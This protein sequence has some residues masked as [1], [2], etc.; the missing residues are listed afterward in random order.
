M[1]KLYAL[2]LCFV[3]AL[4]IAAPAYAADSNIDSGGGNMG[5]ATGASWWS[6]GRDGVRITVIVTVIMPR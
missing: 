6:P 5:E 3:I 1:K 2:F 4:N